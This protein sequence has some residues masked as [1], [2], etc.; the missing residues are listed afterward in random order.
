MFNEIKPDASNLI[1]RTSS[2]LHSE[3]KHFEYS[4]NYKGMCI[5]VFPSEVI[6]MH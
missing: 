5:I 4:V 3:L 1:L 6:H 2:N